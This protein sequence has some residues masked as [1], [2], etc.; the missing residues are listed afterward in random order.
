MFI[1]VTEQIWIAGNLLFIVGSIIG[2]LASKF[3]LDMDYC[4]L[5]IQ[6]HN[7]M[8]FLVSLIAFIGF[9]TNSP[10]TVIASRG[11]SGFLG[12][13]ASVIIPIFINEI[14]PDNLRGQAGVM[15][16]LFTSFFRA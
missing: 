3:Y 16:Y 11:L 1:K 8:S 15:H 12:G 5:S 6:A 2:A 10:L 14:S 9:L 13:M 4:V 7:I